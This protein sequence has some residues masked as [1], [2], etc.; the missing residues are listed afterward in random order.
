MKKIL[1]IILVVLLI[2]CQSQKNAYRL[3]SDEGIKN[4][5]SKQELLDYVNTHCD[6]YYLIEKVDDVSIDDF[7]CD[8]VRLIK[9]VDSLS[10]KESLVRKMSDKITEQL[11]QLKV[12]ELIEKVDL[13]Q[14]NQTD[15][16]QPPVYE[17]P[18]PVKEEK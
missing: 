16:T 1:V 15:N 5:T 9:R 18:K 4:F 6:I 7:Q 8:F 2:S 12:S 17:K 13:T 11:Q 3:E 10:L 14:P